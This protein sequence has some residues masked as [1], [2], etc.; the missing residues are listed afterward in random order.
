[1]TMR[2][3]DDYKKLLST[4]NIGS[5]ETGVAQGWWLIKHACPDIKTVVI[6]RSVEEVVDSLMSADMSGIAVYDKGILTKHMQYGKRM[7]D[8]I[9]DQPG[10]LVINFNDL[11]YMSTGKRLF[12]HC[13]PY[14][15][16]VK[17]WGKFKNQHIEVNMREQFRY[18]DKHRK[19]IQNFKRLCKQELRLIRKYN[20][21]G[22]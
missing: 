13:L 14:E 6:H 8:K 4:P 11:K 3:P 7:L 5:A 22:V 18:Y 16:D 21:M 19:E 1:M 9:S 12:K 2:T 10:T 17:H 20:W 15:F